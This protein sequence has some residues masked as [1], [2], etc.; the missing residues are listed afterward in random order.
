MGYES[1]EKGPY[2]LNE[3][4][5]SLISILGNTERELIFT[6]I[7]NE[8]EFYT[9]NRKIFTPTHFLKTH[10]MNLDANENNPERKN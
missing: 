3:D 1:N 6:S 7:K 5:L 4:T 8:A 10:R 9:D 2:K